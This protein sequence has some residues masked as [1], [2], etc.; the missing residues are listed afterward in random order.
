MHTSTSQLAR[1]L[2]QGNGAIFKRYKANI[3][4]ATVWIRQA[5]TFFSISNSRLLQHY[6]AKAGD[7]FRLTSEETGSTGSEN[8]VTLHLPVLVNEVVDVINPQD[9][10]VCLPAHNFLSF[11]YNRSANQH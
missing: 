1:L 11:I 9:G 8:N 4:L 10:Q 3:F 5:R 6:D 2:L 7:E